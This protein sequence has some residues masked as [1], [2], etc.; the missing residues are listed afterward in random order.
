M[1][2][3]VKRTT[4]LTA[5]D[6]GLGSGAAAVFATVLGLVLTR[7]DPEPPPRS[8]AVVASIAPAGGGEGQERPVAKGSR[9]KPKSRPSRPEP[10]E[11]RSLP[12][13]PSTPHKAARGAKDPARADTP[14]TSTPPVDGGE[15]GVGDGDGPAGDG[16]GS[17]APG[18]DAES[19][20]AYR[21]ELLAWLSGRFVVE[22]SGLDAD[23]LAALK[24]RASVEI[25]DDGRVAGFSLVSPSGHEVVDQA[26]RD[27]LDPLVG[28]FVPSPPEGYP[29]GLPPKLTVTFVCTKSRCS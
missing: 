1:G 6:F 12:T 8:I 17:G 24:V 5:G 23:T 15:G 13:R 14:S 28:R 2:G 16:E 27:A 22:R 9:V 18:L 26:V 11:P 19:I 20:A 4:E 3:D 29:G 7:S 10:E 25:A 21:A